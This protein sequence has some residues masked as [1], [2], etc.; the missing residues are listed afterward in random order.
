MV[1]GGLFLGLLACNDMLDFDP[2][3]E[4]SESITWKTVD[5]FKRAT[6]DLYNNLDHPKYQTDYKADILVEGSQDVVN[7]EQKGY[8]QVWESE[9]TWNSNYAYIRDVNTILEKAAAFR[10]PESL[11]SCVAE[12]KFFRAYFYSKLFCEYGGVPI[13]TEVL[14]V[15]SADLYKPR[16]TR[17]DTF[18]FIIKQLDEA[19]PDLP[20]QSEISDTDY[21]RV[22]RQAAMALRARMC[23]RE[24]TWRKYR[25]QGNCETL[26]SRAAKDAEDIINIP[27]YEIF[28]HP[29]ALGEESYK[30]LFILEDE[31]CNPSTLRKKDNKE[32]I[33]ARKYNSSIKPIG[34]ANRGFAP[35]RKLIDMFVCKNGLPI[36]YNGTINPEFNGYLTKTSEFENRDY[37]MTTL[38]R[39][40]GKVYYGIGSYSRWGN[41]NPPTEVYTNNFGSG[42]STGYFCDKFSSERYVENGGEGFDYPLIRYAEVLLIFAEATYEKNGFISDSELDR[43]INLLR[44]RGGVAPLSNALVS[45]N[46]LNMLEEIRRERTVELYFEGFRLDDLKR[47]NTVKK[48]MTEDI[49]GFYLGSGTPWSKFSR[50]KDIDENGFYRLCKKEERVWEDYYELKPL[51]YDQLRLSKCT[52]EQN[53]GYDAGSCK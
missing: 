44:K 9:G 13:I 8:I 14:D 43:S 30:Y 40:E 18:D 25:G 37:R 52:L 33:L 28:N 46:G 49:C 19:I 17:E 22:S 1:L 26:I 45:Q 32:Y 5:D 3:S 27:Q 41:P 35:T 16:D 50:G 51:P 31:E 12:A 39:Q 7:D 4:P 15:T 47:W 21:G 20:L 53:P 36:R 23:L 2:E 6:G 38:V 42:S 48:E 29:D 11:A 10:D 24:G 34:A